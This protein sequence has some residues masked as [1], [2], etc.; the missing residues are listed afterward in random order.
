M[1]SERTKEKSKSRHYLVLLPFSFKSA[2][3]LIGILE[4]VRDCGLVVRCVM[5]NLSAA[6]KKHIK[7]IS[8]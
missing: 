4:K 1:Q 6:D 5:R 3:I 2:S 8:L 7:L